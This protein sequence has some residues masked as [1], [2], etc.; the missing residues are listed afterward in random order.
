MNRRI[1]YIDFIFACIIVSLFSFNLII[2]T[3]L[4][5][6]F[7]EDN[8]TIWA[9]IIAF[10][11]AIIGG[12]ITYYGV[13][14]QLYSREKELFMSTASEKLIKL[15]QLLDELSILQDQFLSMK[16]DVIKTIEEKN[17][18]FV[19]EIPVTN[20]Y[21]LETQDALYNLEKNLLEKLEIAITKFKKILKKEMNSL[22]IDTYLE[23]ESRKKILYL[24]TVPISIQEVQHIDA[25]V[26]YIDDIILI[27]REEYNKTYKKY[28][29]LNKSSF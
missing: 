17:A 29:K 3:G 14:L 26:K 2:Y 27:F 13:K 6:L 8:E 10:T 4:L 15:D 5:N 11:G 28:K 21:H 18:E 19:K 24:L 9:G 25:K 22:L 20:E 23:Y 1:I 16:K 7:F 12:A